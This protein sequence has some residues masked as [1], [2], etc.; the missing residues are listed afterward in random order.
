MG[1][2]RFIIGKGR[3]HTHTT[4]VPG[5]YLCRRVLVRGDDARQHETLQG[6]ALLRCVSGDKERMSAA[7][8]RNKQRNTHRDT[9]THRHTDTHKHT[10]HTKKNSAARLPG[11]P[12]LAAWGSA[13]RGPRPHIPGRRPAPAQPPPG[14]QHTRRWRGLWWVVWTK[15]LLCMM[16]DAPT[17]EQHHTLVRTQRLAFFPVVGSGRVGAPQHV[18]SLPPDPNDEAVL[19]VF[20]CTCFRSEG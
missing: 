6:V 14:A 16:I 9:Q 1:P 18:G 10:Q 12:A 3:V 17:T 2:A 8:P 11:P 13:P 19:C 20:I 7:D 4:H 15:R 5:E